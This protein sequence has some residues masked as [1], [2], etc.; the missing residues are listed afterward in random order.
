MNTPAALSLPMGM[1]AFQPH[2]GLAPFYAA[3]RKRISSFQLLNNQGAAVMI[4][5]FE[6]GEAVRDMAASCVPR[7]QASSFRKWAAEQDVE[8]PVNDFAAA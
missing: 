3:N 6:N 8:L 7:D 5:D 4:L 2:V 1:M